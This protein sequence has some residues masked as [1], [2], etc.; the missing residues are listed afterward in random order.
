MKLFRRRALVCRDFVEL[1]TAY[2]DGAMDDRTRARVERH[3]GACDAC[4]RY[5]E[6]FRAVIRMTGRL[7]ETDVAAIDPATREEL[8]AAFAAASGGD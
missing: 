8:I 7:R 5:L 1:V 6:Q 4:T 2:L 3:L